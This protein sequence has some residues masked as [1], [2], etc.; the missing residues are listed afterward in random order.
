MKQTLGCL[1]VLSL[2]V[3]AR[4]DVKESEEQV[5]QL[6]IVVG[7]TIETMQT[8]KDKETAEKAKPALTKLFEEMDRAGK[9]FSKTP[10]EEKKKL[11]EQYKAKFDDVRKKFR[12]EIDRLRKDAAISKV[13]ADVGPFKVNTEAKVTLARYRIITLEKAA[14]LY[15][16]RDTNYPETLAALTEGEKPIVERTLLTDPWGK[17]FQYDPKGP[18]NKGAKPD[19]W[20]VEPGGKTIGNW[21]EKTAPPKKEK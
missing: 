9:Q 11:E 6:L 12:A 5:K 20:T 21:D 19:I 18:K 1:L 4:A 13:L 17:A 14:D 2:A 8:V 16:L 10:E 3:V 15:K 7:K